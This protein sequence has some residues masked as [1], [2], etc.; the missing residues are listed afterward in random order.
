MWDK[1]LTKRI[2]ECLKFWEKKNIRNHQIKKL[3]LYINK[4]VL[5][6]FKFLIVSSNI[7][8]S[9][10]IGVLKIY[11]LRYHWKLWSLRIQKVWRKLI[12]DKVRIYKVLRA[13]NRLLR[14]STLC[15]WYFKGRIFTVFSH[16]S[17]FKDPSLF[18]KAFY[19]EFWSRK[20]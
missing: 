18:F 5:K 8:K 14:R 16:R 3:H 9:D 12:K 4:S 2:L 13:R 6:L 20:F 15:F 19:N 11:S 7:H 1:F 17:F 10:K